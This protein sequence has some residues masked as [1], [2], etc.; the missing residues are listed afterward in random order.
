MTDGFCKALAIFFIGIMTFD[1]S[2]NMT[3]CIHTYL[4]QIIQLPRLTRFN[5]DPCLAVCSTKMSVITNKFWTYMI[6]TF[7]LCKR[8]AFGHILVGF[9]FPAV[10]LV[11][12]VLFGR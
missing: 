11:Y 9:G 5:T 2:Y 7:C 4:C 12:L 3:R 6:F 8:F 10:V 1:I